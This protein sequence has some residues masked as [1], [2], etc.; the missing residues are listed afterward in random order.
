MPK[1][2]EWPTVRSLEKGS[3]YS[4]YLF[5][6]AGGNEWDFGAV[7]PDANGDWKIMVRNKSEN[8]FP[9]FQDWV[10]VLETRGARR[11]PSP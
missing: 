9:L 6:P 5:D 8:A 4:A 7:H 1:V 2:I 3:S 11:P 10:I